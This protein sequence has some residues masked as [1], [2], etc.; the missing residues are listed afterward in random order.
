MDA[1]GARHWKIVGYA[2]RH[3]EKLYNIILESMTEET[4]TAGCPQKFYI[5]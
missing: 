5:K 4:K 1:I 3:P 2:L